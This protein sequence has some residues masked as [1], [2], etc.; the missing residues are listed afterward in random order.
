MQK[1]ISHTVLIVTK[2]PQGL[3][4]VTNFFRLF[5]K[6]FTNE[7]FTLEWQTIGSRPKDYSRRLERRFAYL[8]EFMKDLR[9]IIQRLFRDRSIQ[10]VHLNPSL[11]PVPL[12]R[13]GI[14]L[15]LS[16]FFGRKV[17]VLIHGWDTEFAKK[18]DSTFWIKFLFRLVYNR[19]DKIV[20][21]ADPFI[22]KLLEW[23]INKALV[24]TT[25]T[26]YDGDQILS[27]K[28]KHPDPP[29]FI[30]LSRI[31][32]PKGVFEI[33]E[34]T[35]KLKKRGYLFNVYFYGYEGTPGVLDELK[36]LSIKLN[37]EDSLHFMGYIDGMKKYRAY[38]EAD[39]FLL[40]TYHPEGF[41]TVILEAMASKCF[42][43]TTEVG[44]LKEIIQD[45][46]QGK[47]V[48]PKDPEDLA[49]KMAWCLDNIETVRSLGTQNEE[50]AKKRFEAGFVVSQFQQIYTELANKRY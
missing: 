10:V 47:I 35:A 48:K 29:S 42:I 25:S 24:A 46:V 37:L 34:A 50:Y 30:F 45:G 36:S 4:R 28:I 18:I 49:E 32:R 20:A 22:H 14:L 5:F 8:C 41:P 3:G 21:L 1:K 39:V 2:D 31:N 38:A 40:P 26:M 6:K 44:A 43:I 11:I 7:R 16:R 33:V 17:V 15:L 27:E 13:D 12:V 19:A 9:V 23:G